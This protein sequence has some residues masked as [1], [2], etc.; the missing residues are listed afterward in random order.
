LTM[1]V[2]GEPGG[3]FRL[4]EPLIQRAVKRQFRADLETLKDM[5]ETRRG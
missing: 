5:L 2:E 1:V 4:A 3:F